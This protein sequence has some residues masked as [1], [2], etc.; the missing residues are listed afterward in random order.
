MGF[1]V[2]GLNLDAKKLRD[3]FMTAMIEVIFPFKV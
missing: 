3:Y 2:Y 1:L